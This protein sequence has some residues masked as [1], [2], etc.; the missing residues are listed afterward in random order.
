MTTCNTRCGTIALLGAPNAG[1]SSLTN[2]LVGAKVSIVTHKVQTTR[3]RITGIVMYDNTQMV[4]VDTPGIFKPKKRLDRAMVSTAWAA[5]DSADVMC[6]LVD[7]TSSDKRDTTGILDT[8]AQQ[9]KT[10]VLILNKIDLVDKKSLFAMTEKFWQL[11]IFSDVFMVSATNG[12]G[13]PSLKKALA[14]HMPTGEYMFDT[15]DI[16]TIPDRL[17]AAEITREKVFLN[18]HQELPYTITVETEQWHHFR[19]GDIKITQVIF[20]QRQNHRSI[21]LGKQGRTIKHIGTQARTELSQ[22]FDTKVHV[23]LQVKVKQ[24]WQNDIERYH[25]MGLDFT[26]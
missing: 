13:V 22:L 24:N 21:V 3:T 14:S 11:G 2:I 12:S 19:N 9:N 6:V 15:D 25:A 10:A 23:L 8:L 20:V 1:K 16:S 4:I 26:P 17:L 18:I 5:A 7:A